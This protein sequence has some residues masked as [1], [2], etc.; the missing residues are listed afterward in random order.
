MGLIANAQTATAWTGT[1]AVAPQQGTIDASFNGLSQQTMRQILHTSIGGSTARVQ[2]S[3]VFGKQALTVQ[4]VHLA[5]AVVDSNGGPTSSTIPGTD[6][7]VTFGGFTTVTVPA[8][9]V[10]ASDPIAFPTTPQEDLMVSIYFPTAVDSENVTTHQNG[11]QN[12]MFLAAGDVS[13]NSTINATSAFS[14]YFYLTNVDV[15]NTAATGAVV[16]IGA[17]ITDGL[18]SSF[19]TNHRWT[20]DLSARLNVAGLQVGVINEG[21][22]GNDLLRDGAGQAMVTRFSR[23]VLSQ[24]NVRW[25]IVSDD[26]INDLSNLPSDQEPSFDSLI[27][28]MQQIMSQAHAAGIKFY[29]STLTPNGGRP[30]AQWSTGAEA[31]REQVN[32]FFLSPSSGCDGIVDQ[33]TATHDPTMPLQ[34]RPSFDSGDHLHP[35]DA[36]H[37]AIANAVNLGLFTS[38][39]IPPIKAPTGSCS[40]LLAGEGLIPD[41]P[42]ISCDGRFELYLQDDGNLVIYFG[43]TPLWSTGTVGHI[44]SEVT[45]LADGNFVLY[46]IN[47]QVLWQSKTAGLL[48]QEINMQNDGNLVL[49]NGTAASASPVWATNT[50][51]H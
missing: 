16:A 25:V 8:G 49:Y 34:Y 22:S 43:S 2:I 7:T 35:N 11:G 27:A 14:S 42:L 21:I 1:W 19:N 44:P 37:Q 5:Q 36:G 51:C 4:D 31:I 48:G 45:L 18:N 9:Q 50:C 33:D 41:H 3:N 10:M 40:T 23:D 46:D 26:I 15:Q 17:S 39:G 29:C 6:H 30:A 20:N 24:P 12:G 38:T 32:A 28:G 13:R 47:G